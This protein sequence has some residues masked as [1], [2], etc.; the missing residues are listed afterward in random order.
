MIYKRPFCKTIRFNAPYSHLQLHSMKLH[1]IRSQVAR[2]PLHCK[3]RR[4]P[5]IREKFLN[6]QPIEPRGEKTPAMV[7]E[8]KKHLCS[9][10]VI[11]H[12]TRLA[13]N[14][15]VKQNADIGDITKNN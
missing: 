13:A 14:L 15:V 7:V 8:G 10:H 2:Y 11:D 5:C 4:K 1:S 6:D 3:F 12:H 9:L